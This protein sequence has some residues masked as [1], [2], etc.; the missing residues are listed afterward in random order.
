MLPEIIKLFQSIN[1]WIIKIQQYFPF[2]Q[3]KSN[4]IAAF[5]ILSL[6]NPKYR[7]ILH[8]I[9]QMLLISG[10]SLNNAFIFIKPNTKIRNFFRRKYWLQLSNFAHNA[11]HTILSP[12]CFQITNFNNCSM[13]FP[14]S[15]RASKNNCF[16]GEIR[17]RSL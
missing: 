10:F 9:H 11:L 2:V 8:Q 1:I 16:F 6:S 13:T 3:Q 5:T 17:S 14:D 7:F 15:F 4:Y 12:F